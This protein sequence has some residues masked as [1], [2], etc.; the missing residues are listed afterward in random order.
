[1]RLW[2]L[3]HKRFQRTAF[4]GEGTYLVGGRWVPA[5]RR[6]VYASR[7]RSLA[8]LES[9]VHMEVRHMR[10]NFVAFPIDVPFDLD[11]E[12]IDSGPDYPE[13]PHGQ[14]PFHP[15][16]AKLPRH[17]R[18]DRAQKKLQEI[19]VR[20]IRAAKTCLLRVPSAVVPQESNFLINPA[21][22][23]FQRLAIG[24]PD[25]FGFDHRLAR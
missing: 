23:E 9:L 21:H 14:K 24:K 12:S 3:T 8:V 6:I 1:M 11:I 22:P 17:W 20:W 13:L 2:R 18:E 10:D 4:S 19:G 15:L 16:A 7:T 5:G 25:V